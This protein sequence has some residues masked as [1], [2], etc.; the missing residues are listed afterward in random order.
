MSKGRNMDIN[1]FQFKW[2]ALIHENRKRI[3]M[4]R[5]LTN[6][7]LLMLKVA[8]ALLALVLLIT[9]LFGTHVTLVL[10]TRQYNWW[11]LVSDIFVIIYILLLMISRWVIDAS[12]I[13]N[14]NKSLMTLLTFLCFLR[15]EVYTQKNMKATKN[16]PRIT[17]QIQRVLA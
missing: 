16:S 5:L 11:Y 14:D 17:L 7:I 3:K 1:H 6:I 8:M 2:M 4:I 10:M 9:L 13:N 15:W 12:I